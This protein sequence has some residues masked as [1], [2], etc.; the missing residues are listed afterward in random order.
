MFRADI[1]VITRRVIVEVT[2]LSKT[3]RAMRNCGNDYFG[4]ASI[5]LYL[6][7]LQFFTDKQL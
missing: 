7:A 1:Q 5:M 6:D 3:M 2:E 4:K